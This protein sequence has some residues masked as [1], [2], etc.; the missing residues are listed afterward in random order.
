MKSSLLLLCLVLVGTKAAAQKRY[1]YLP[2]GKT[3]FE[4]AHEKII[5]KYRNGFNVNKLSSI[6]TAASIEQEI[7]KPKTWKIFDLKPVYR[8]QDSVREILN[9]LRKTGQIQYANPFLIYADGTRQ[10]LTDQLIV[11]L[12]K[13]TNYESLTSFFKKLNVISSSKSAYMDGEYVLSIAPTEGH[14]AL[15][16]ANFL[17]ETGKF[18][19]CEPDFIK[20][21]MFETNDPV[22]NFQWGLHNTGQ[23]N[24]I[25]GADLNLL[26]AWGATTGAGIRVAVLD[27]GVDL[28]HP[29]LAAN[30]VGGFDAL[31]LGS[32]GG[33]AGDDAHGTGCA[34][35]IGAIAN[36]NLGVAGVAYSSRIVPVRIG[37]NDAISTTAAAAGINW[38]VSTTGGNA[39]VLSCS[40]G[41]GSSSSSVNTAISNAVTTGRGG[42]GAVV[43]FASG[44]NN[45]SVAWPANLSNVIAVGGTNPCDQRFVI[46][47]TTPNTSCNYDTRLN[48]VS[49]NAGSNFGT[50][51][52]VVAPGINVATTD[53]AGAAGFSNHVADQG[54][55][56]FNQDY[57]QNFDGTSAA[58]PFAAGAVALILSINPNL[59]NAQAT[60]ILESTASKVGGYNYSTNLSNGTW[61]NEMG[62]GRINVGAAVCQ[63]LSTLSIAGQNPVCS[64]NTYSISN[65]P[66]GFGF[67]WSSNNTSGL[68]INSAT[69]AASPVANFKGQVTI[70]ASVNGAG[71][72]LNYSETVWVGAPP[73]DNSYLVWAAGNRGVNPLQVATGSSYSFNVDPVP[74]TTSYTWQPPP[75]FAVAGSKTTFSPS[76]SITTS[77]TEGTY[78][79]Y[80]R[81]NNACGFSWTNSL[82]LNNV[83]GGGGCCPQIAVYPNP[84]Q[85]ELIIM[86]SS[87]QEAS[88]QSIQ[89][90]E[91]V[92]GYTA[93]F[94]DDSNKIIKSSA[95]KDGRIVFDLIE[96]KEGIYF[97]K[98]IQGKT[99]DTR[100]ILI[101]K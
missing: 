70:G 78:I 31:G 27:E 94:V 54:W 68:T 58:C 65:L 25:V 21:G 10:G 81:A 18:E 6:C 1:A 57:V 34:G 15:D 24:G 46:T 49:I 3:D 37:S 12:K 50:G 64:N 48:I 56:M 8:N 88:S 63:A 61:N 7:A 82:T 11:R 72:A 79:L 14:D 91:S 26:Q 95:S 19:Y 28:N 9:A 39:D 32:N 52:A 22:Y 38:A 62:Y 92:P 23:Y 66:A 20:V 100:R 33:P 87:V 76:I 35:I 84:T 29:D 97:L 2:E 42:R 60:A 69:G 40:W 4:T 45:T 30:L 80:C 41:G 86:D 98:I 59:T 90:S 67:N 16:V 73:A 93:N 47:P 55:A 44:N 75:G 71:C 17:F 53:I 43:L 89:S 51:L 13:T 101:K 85:N 77:N 99:T 96:V 74:N 5:V 36:N 83:A